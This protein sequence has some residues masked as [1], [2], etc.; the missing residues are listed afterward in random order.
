MV[1]IPLV[2]ALL[3]ACDGAAIHLEEILADWLLADGALLAVGRTVSVIAS[4][5]ELQSGK[6]LQQTSALV[7]SGAPIGS[8]AVATL[9]EQKRSYGPTF[10]PSIT[11]TFPLMMGFLHWTHTSELA[12]LNA[13]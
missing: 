2:C 9:C 12:V 3:A 6:R 8:T 11:T 1:L 13:W 5:V 10:L 7:T 4:R